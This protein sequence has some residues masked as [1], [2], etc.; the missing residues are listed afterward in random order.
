MS[1]NPGTPGPCYLKGKVGDKKKNENIWGARQISACDSHSQFKLH[2]KR[3]IHPNKKV[4][5]SKS[6]SK[7]QHHSVS[8]KKTSKKLSR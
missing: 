8:S 5:V 4:T 6:L 3:V 2:R 7:I 1:Y